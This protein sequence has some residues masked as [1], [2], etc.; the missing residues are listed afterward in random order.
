[1][2]LLDP[3]DHLDR[4]AMD[5]LA[6][7]V[8]KETRESAT[9]VHLARPDRKAFADRL[10]TMEIPDRPAHLVCQ[11]TRATSDLLATRERREILDQWGHLDRT[12]HLGCQELRS[13]STLDTVKHRRFSV[14]LLVDCK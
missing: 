7:K 4:R 12:D 11:E 14:K 8:R 2:A 5:F 10:E 13:S 1:M 3:Q 9:P 6:L